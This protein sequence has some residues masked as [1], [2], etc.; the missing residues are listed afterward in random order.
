MKKQN[1]TDQIDGS[2]TTFTVQESY[3]TGSLRV[4]WN[5]IRQTVSVTF[6]EASSTTFTTTFTALTGDYLTIDYKPI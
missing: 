6:S 3:E 1:V 2:K 4:Y 5:G